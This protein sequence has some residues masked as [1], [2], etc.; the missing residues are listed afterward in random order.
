MAEMRSESL[1]LIPPAGASDVEIASHLPVPLR[2]PD[3]RFELARFALQLEQ[4]FSVAVGDA[5]LVGCTHRQLLQEGASFGHGL[6]GMVD[7]KH[8]AVDAAKLQKQSEESRRE[9]EAGKCVVNVLP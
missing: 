8:H 5:L 9:K 6:I 1:Q 2:Q 7:R 3:M 4:L